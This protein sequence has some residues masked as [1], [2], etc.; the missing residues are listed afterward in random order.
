MSDIERL[1]DR[2]SPDGPPEA[3]YADLGWP[4][5]PPDRPHTRINMAATLDGRAVVSPN[6]QGSEGIGSA[7]DRMLVK[8]LRQG[9]DAVMLGAATVRA[10]PV[11]YAPHLLRVVVTGSGDL[12][13]HKPF[14]TDPPGQ[15]LAFMPEDAGDEAAARLA[16][17]AGVERCG[18]GRVDLGEA[19]RLL[20][21][22]HSV[23]RMLIEGGGRLNAQA[24]AAGIVDEVFVTVAPRI[25]FGL[26]T[27]G[28]S[29][30][31]EGVAPG[32][33]DLDLVSVYRCGSELFL[34][35]HVRLGE[36]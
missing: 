17:H 28:I 30:A 34:R 11:A 20:R 8:R 22:R 29:A 10:C 33:A 32:L 9:A 27:P 7:T 21:A 18:A 15:V 2:T 3:L 14:F 6:G 4:E 36:G 25:S 1:Y 26:D 12:P 5:P 13:V 16:G 24:L 31:P 35:Y 23:R 19:A